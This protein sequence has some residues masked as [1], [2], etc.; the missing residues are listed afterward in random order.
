M[1]E[2]D[3][4]FGEDRIQEIVENNYRLSA[5]EM[6]EHIISAVRDHAGRVSQSDDITLMVIRRN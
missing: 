2:N 3:E 6:V 1:N 5:K 4:E